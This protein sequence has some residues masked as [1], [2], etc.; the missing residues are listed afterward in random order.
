[1]V[2]ARRFG[3]NWTM[4]D[5]IL[6]DGGVGHLNMAEK[7][8][9]EELGLAVNIGAV[10]KGRERNKLDLRFK[11]YDPRNEVKEVFND[12]NLIKRIMDEA[13]RFAIGYHRKLGRKDF[14]LTKRQ[15]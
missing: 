13:H 6:L 3:N 10:A 9:H 15:K 14:I 11:I 5:L 8:L 2:L 12:K 7:L 4:P 1:E